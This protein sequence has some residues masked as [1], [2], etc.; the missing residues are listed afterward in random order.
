MLLRMLKMKK[1]RSQDKSRKS[2]TC[3][4]LKFK[5]L[6]KT[7]A[8]IALTNYDLKC[9]GAASVTMLLFIGLLLF[10][11]RKVARQTGHVGR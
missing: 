10:I 3:F 4:Y 2:K 8:I 7:F 9:R 5:I 1:K 6:K 11:D